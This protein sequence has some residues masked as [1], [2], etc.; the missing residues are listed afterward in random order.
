MVLPVIAA[1]ILVAVV[2]AIAVLL[3]R[4]GKTKHTTT[5]T[6]AVTV[7]PPVSH[8]FLTIEYDRATEAT[9]QMY[10][11]WQHDDRAIALQVGTPAAVDQLFR[12]PFKDG[13]ANGCNDAS[14]SEIDCSYDYG[15]TAVGMRYDVKSRQITEARLT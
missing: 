7:A 2:V 4:E 5:R 8:Q 15:T 6:T 11:A 12:L 10:S 1:G 13:K 14:S 3:T 9:Q